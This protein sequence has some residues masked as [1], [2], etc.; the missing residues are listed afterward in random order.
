MAYLAFNEQEAIKGEN[1]ENAEYAA[2][3]ET[4]VLNDYLSPL[5]LNVRCRIADQAKTV[6]YQTMDCLLKTLFGS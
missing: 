5:V 3:M 4:K 1:K 6:F 2:E